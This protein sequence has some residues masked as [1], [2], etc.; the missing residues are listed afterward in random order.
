MKSVVFTGGGTGGHIFPGLAIAD[1]LKKIDSSV[2]ITWIGSTS[3]RDKKM[4]LSNIAEDG[5]KSCTRY[6]SIP[7]G[8]LRRYFSF[9]NAIDVFKIA[10]GFVVSIILLLHIKPKFV[11]SKGGF[12]SVPPCAAAK[13]LGIP[14]YTHECDYSPGLA[15]KLNSRFA[16]KILVSYE[17]TKKFFSKNMHSKIVVTGNPV[18]GI[19]YNTDKKIGYSFLGLTKSKKPLLLVLGG[20]SGAH[21]INSLVEHNLKRLL[22]NFTIVHQTGV[23]EDYTNALN[24]KGEHYLPFDFIYSQM[25]HVVACSDI[26]FSRSGANSLWECA[27]LGKPMVLLPLSGSGTRGDQVE[28][29][30]VFEKKGAALVVDSSETDSAVLSEQVCSSLESFLDNDLRQ[31]KA[32]ASSKMVKDNASKKIA[33]FL[34]DELGFKT[35]KE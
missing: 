14:V 3:E 33:Q 10:L 32:E 18:R 30:M 4:V 19:F 22:K 34:I 31:R 9:Q 16:K 29:A 26:V 28:N 7:S 25:P 21:Q 35:S 11:F 15:T 8:K 1:E 20:S 17:D 24:K 12:V 23:G 5:S 2:S 6:F 13:L 27:V